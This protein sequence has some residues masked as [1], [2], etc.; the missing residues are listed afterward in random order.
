M[1]ITSYNKGSKFTYKIPEDF[2]YVSLK[3]LYERIPKDMRASAVFPVNAL[4]INTKG[5]FGEHAVLCSGVYG[6]DLPKHLTAVVKQILEDD[7]SIEEIN[8]GMVYFNI[9]EYI[10]KNY[11]NTKAYSIEFVSAKDMK[12]ENEVSII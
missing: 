12:S 6:V 9:R 3:E 11:E 1:K 2:N 4:Y 5:M 8:S 7:E 10:P